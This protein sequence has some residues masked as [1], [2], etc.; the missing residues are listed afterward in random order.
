MFSLLDFFKK[1]VTPENVNCIPS[2]LSIPDSPYDSFAARLFKV[3]KK[4]RYGFMHFALMSYWRESVAWLLCNFSSNIDFENMMLPINI[5]S[6][7]TN[8]EEYEN[9]NFAPLLQWCVYH[10]YAMFHMFLEA[11][12]RV[13]AEEVFDYIATFEYFKANSTLEH[14]LQKGIGINHNAQRHTETREL[15][16]KYKSRRTRCEA[17]VVRLLGLLRFKRTKYFSGLDPRLLKQMVVTPVWKTRYLECW[18]TTEV[19]KLKI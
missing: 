1:V 13:G 4:A 6:F 12:V 5:T 17:V 8:I 10:S 11:G 2:D 16:Q 14:M 15:I 3:C 7:V 19:K 9:T 18:D